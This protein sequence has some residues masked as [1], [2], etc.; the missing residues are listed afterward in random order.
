MSITQVTY[1][2][3]SLVFCLFVC[4]LLMRTLM[5]SLMRSLLRLVIL[6]LRALLI[7]V[8][9]TTLNEEREKESGKSG[10]IL[11]DP[12]LTVVG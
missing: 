9:S 7:L 3:H 8:S 10:Y 1:I 4:S 2:R 11:H 5:R 6:A 12:E